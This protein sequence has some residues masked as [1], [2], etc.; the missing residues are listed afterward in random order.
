MS[1]RLMIVDEGR[2]QGG[3][4][5]I[6]ISVNAVQIDGHEFDHPFTRDKHGQNE[7]IIRWSL[8]SRGD[9]ADQM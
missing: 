9:K 2:K 8:F 1:C 5:L 3:A 4:G 6:I 7:N